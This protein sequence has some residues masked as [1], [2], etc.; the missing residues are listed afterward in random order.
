MAFKTPGPSTSTLAYDVNAPG[1]ANGS[2][3]KV[4][5][6][7]IEDAL[8]AIANGECVIVVDD[9]DRE[10]EGDIIMAARECTTEKMAWIIRHSSGYICLAMSPERLD[11]LDIPLMIIN[12]T[13]NYKT[14]YTH[15]VDYRAGVSTGI[16][17]HDR[18]LT[19]RK[20]ADPTSKPSD[21]NRPG[22]VVPL[23]ARA[24]G[25]LERRGHTEAAVDLVRLSGLQGAPVGVI[26]EL[27]KQ[28]DPMGSMARRDDCF[29]FAR[30]WGCKMISIEQLAEH[31]RRNQL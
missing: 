15:T 30:Q 8:Q 22:H 26:C 21:F 4:E 19:S 25:V 31:R 9:M 5:L 29:A 13:E 1:K 20:L 2:A 12:N 3:V 10:N 18:A 16:S 14:A 28:D 6:D 27:L 17:A 11:E 7:S 24:G 23:R